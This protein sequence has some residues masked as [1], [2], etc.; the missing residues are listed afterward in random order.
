[1]QSPEQNAGYIV[2]V[3]CVRTVLIIR[4]LYVYLH[5]GTVIVNAPFM[6][7]DTHL[8]FSQ[9]TFWVFYACKDFLWGRVCLLLLLHF[10]SPS[11]PICGRANS[12][13]C[14]GNCSLS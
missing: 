2:S 12:P 10:Y 3:P 4:L 7:Y 8:Y 13:G 9:R 1:M 14:A 11:P 5:T 6:L